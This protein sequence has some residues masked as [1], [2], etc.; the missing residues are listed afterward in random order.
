[1]MDRTDD[2]REEEQVKS[3][4]LLES[5][6]SLFNPESK[7]QREEGGAEWQGQEVGPKAAGDERAATTGGFDTSSGLKSVCWPPVG[8]QD[9]M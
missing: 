1:M 5:V 9:K 4:K 2:G 8:P 7:K 3:Q 6:A